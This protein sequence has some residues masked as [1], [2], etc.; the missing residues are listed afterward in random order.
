MVKTAKCAHI[1]EI[2][3]MSK[4]QSLDLGY[5]TYGEVSGDAPK[6]KIE[7]NHIFDDK[8]A[9]KLLREMAFRNYESVICSPRIEK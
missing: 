6:Q 3:I 1:Q 2:E 9:N 7:V 8:H 4:Y 5:S